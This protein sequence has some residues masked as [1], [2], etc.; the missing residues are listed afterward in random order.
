MNFKQA[1][2]ALLSGKKIRISTWDKIC[3]WYLDEKGFV[4][5]SANN[6]PL[7]HKSMIKEQNKWEVKD[8][9]DE[10]QQYFEM[11]NEWEKRWRDQEKKTEYWRNKY[12]KL[13]RDKINQ[14]MGER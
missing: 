12:A 2:E 7:I 11:A 1:T 8:K 13:L 9:N 10:A 6:R 14:T 3:Y 5:D 4:R